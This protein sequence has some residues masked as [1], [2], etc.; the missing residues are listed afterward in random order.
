MARHPANRISKVA[1]E[2]QSI[3]IRQHRPRNNL[4]S[5]R[6]S[7]LRK[8]IFYKVTGLLVRTTAARHANLEVAHADATVQT[9]AGGVEVLV[10]QHV[11]DAIGKLRRNTQALGGDLQRRKS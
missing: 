5:I 1:K 11:R 4:F 7:G 9:N 2:K 10:V 6:V 3:I 8:F